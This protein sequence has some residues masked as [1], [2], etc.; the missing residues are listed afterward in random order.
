MAVDFCDPPEPLGGVLEPWLGWLDA[1]L[2]A[3][4]D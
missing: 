2:E 4:L 1:A 3:A